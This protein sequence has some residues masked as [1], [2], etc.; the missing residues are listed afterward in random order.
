MFGPLRERL[1]AVEP[2]RVIGDS[3][4]LEGALL[5]TYNTLLRDRL[6]GMYVGIVLY[7]SPRR[8]TLPPFT[9]PEI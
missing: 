9:S 8:C 6:Q 7:T 4:S 2:Y 5:R 1:R 3:V